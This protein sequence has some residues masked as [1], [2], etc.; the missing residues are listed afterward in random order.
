[1]SSIFWL[2]KDCICYGWRGPGVEEVG[3]GGHRLF[4]CGSGGEGYFVLI[5]MCDLYILS[6]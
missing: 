2:V 5:K 6:E 3:G 1:M 4:G